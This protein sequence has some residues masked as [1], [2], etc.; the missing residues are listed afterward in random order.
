MEGVAGEGH[1]AREG[2]NGAAAS[3]FARREIFRTVGQVLWR[4]RRRAG[5]ALV[6]LVSAKLF[7]VLVP[8]LLKRIVD[9]LESTG[10]PLVLPVFLLLGYAM[11]RFCAGLFTELRDVVF[12]RVTQTAV[13]DFTVRMFEHLHSLDV[14]FLG[15]RQTG[16]LSR[17][18]ERGTAGVG[19]LM[20]TALFTVLPTIVEIVS[21]IAIMIMA[22]RL[23]FS[24]IVLLTFIVYAV[25]TVVFTE[26]RTFY[27]RQLNELDSAANGHLVDSLLNYETVKFYASDKFESQRLRDIMRRWIGIGVDNQRALSVL[28]VGQSGIIAFGVAAVMLLAGQEVVNGK[29]AIGDLILINAYMI[30]VCLP[31]NT[32]GLSFRQAREA[33]VNAE[34]MSELLRYPPE[35]DPADASPALRLSGGAV[36]FSAVDFSYEPGRQILHEVDFRIEPG[37]TVAVVGGSGSGKSTLAR[38]LLRFYDVDNGS[39]AVDGQDVRSVS[40][41]SLRSAIGVVPQDSLLFNNT[42]A[43]NIAYGRVGASLAEVIEAAKAAR[44]HELI[45]SLPAQ[46][47]TLVGERGVK[48]SGGERQRIAI[49]RAVLKNPPLLV[50]DEATS[51][52]D[53]RTERAI[54]VELDRLAQGRSTLIIAHRLS[55]IVDADIILVMDHGRI[56]ERGSHAEL[57]R[58]KGLYAQMWNLQR[59]QNELD[60]SG[61]RLSAQP[62]NLVTLVAG[63]LDAMRPA[64]EAKGI[65]L[66]TLISPDTTRVTGDPSA[67]QQLVCDLCDNAIAFTPA[68]GRMELRL[69]RDGDAALIS[70]TDGR[71]SP[72]DATSQP[73]EDAAPLHAVQLLDPLQAAAVLE[74]MQG[75]FDASP[76]GDGSGM[77]FS[78]RLPLRAVATLAPPSPLSE[79]QANILDGLRIFIAD[80]QQEARELLAA[81]LQDFGAR[82]EL[83]DSGGALLSALHESQRAGWPDVLVCDISLGEP[84][85]YQVIADIR[86]LEAQRGSSLAQRL[87]AIALSGYSQR[88]DRL[89]ALL[90]GFQVHVAKPVDPRELIATVLA[91]TRP[92]VS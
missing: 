16:G 5:A 68:G 6:L 2:R 51:A 87:P 80:D 3:A 24:G 36:A 45:Q 59:Q 10:S 79:G 13:A 84:D 38:L 73:V 76:A 77:T 55:T 60:E 81:V 88:E 69:E 34:R 41:K 26:R 20:G 58:A 29:M 35:A 37:A 23:G 52:L 43:Y 30:Q 61:S 49:A 62:V 86:R 33:L 66:Y 39:I 71:L 4:F 19:F 28:H 78:I 7:A 11:L 72:A 12:A 90:A 42:I 65:V 82:T 83:F 14:K 44:I 67:L 47:E 8:V 46:Y 15:S 32:L 70:V 1:R 91:V 74:Q 64:I 56:V 31:L 75:A 92:K 89:R 22:Y 53:T 27:Q 85:G 57:L 50:F 54:Q 63:V 25:F 17:D 21:V 9:S 40:Q 48:L 18:V